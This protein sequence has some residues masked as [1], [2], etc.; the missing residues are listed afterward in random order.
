ME[1]V[2]G[3]P[4]SYNWNNSTTSSTI[5]V[6]ATSSLINSYSVI[7]SDGCTIPN[8]MAYFSLT[9]NSCVGIEENNFE[10]L[11]VEVFLNPASICINIK[12]SSYIDNYYLK[13]YLII[14]SELKKVNTVN[15]TEILNIDELKSGVYFISIFNKAGIRLKTSKIFIQH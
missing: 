5:T 4:Y 11:I 13:M 6:T 3:G 7:V 14:G 10:N 2:I 9:V 1:L 15:E 12:L 8:K